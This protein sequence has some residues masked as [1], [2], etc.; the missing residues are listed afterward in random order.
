MFP[1]G[2]PSNGRNLLPKGLGQDLAEKVDCNCRRPCWDSVGQLE[3]LLV[4]LKGYAGALG[5]HVGITLG[6]L[7]FC[8]WFWNIMPARKMV[9]CWDCGVQFVALL[10][11]SDGCVGPLGDHVGTMVGTLKLS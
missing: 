1:K 8:W 10:N 11:A 7:R 5:H 9:K 2:P 3:A 4:V 6:S